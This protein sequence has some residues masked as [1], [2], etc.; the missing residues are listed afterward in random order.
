MSASLPKPRG[1]ISCEVISAL[2]GG[3]PGSMALSPEVEH[4]DPNGGDLQLALQLCYELHYRGFAGVDPDWE[5]D[6]VLIGVRTELERLFLRSLRG[7][8]A[9][10]CEADRE[11][12]AVSRASVEEAGVSHFLRESGTWQQVREFFAHRSIYHLKE[13]DPHAWVIP[14]LEGEAKCALVAVE[15]DEF[16]AG[17]P[18]RMHSGLFSDLLRAA[19]LDASYLAYLDYVPPETLATVNFMSLCGLH[20]GL[21]GALV[22]HFAAAEITTSPSARRM[23][24]ALERVEAPW[25]CIHFYAEHV[26]ADAVHEQILRHDV[27]GALLEQEPELAADVVFGI[28]ATE[29]LENRLSAHVLGCWNRGVSSLD[30]PV[31]TVL[32]HSVGRWSAR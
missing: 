9:G 12:D 6:P 27:V 32:E 2:E 3:A 11:L 21:R 15:Y 19:R 24:E 22:G 4:A 30:G 29:L 10:G 18:E 13:A 28:Q 8:V 16:G 25:E 20:R 5:W 17:R 26:E 31:A 14:R 7:A 23:V 1:P